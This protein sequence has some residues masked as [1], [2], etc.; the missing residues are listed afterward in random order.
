MYLMC[1]S[2]GEGTIIFV[3]LLEY[4]N[5]ICLTIFLR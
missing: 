4:E 5:L 2:G 3:I 1:I